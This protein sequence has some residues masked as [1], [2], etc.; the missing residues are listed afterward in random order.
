MQ[1][2]IV[3]CRLIESPSIL[4]YYKGSKIEKNVPFALNTIIA[5][6][7]SQAMNF[8]SK[9]VAQNLCKKL[10]QDQK[11]LHKLGFTTFQVT[12]Q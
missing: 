4:L 11:S 5:F 8:K 2:F 1:N 12:T 10:N 9:K 3:F 6:D 7:P